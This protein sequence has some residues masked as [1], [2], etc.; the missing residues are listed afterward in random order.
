MSRLAAVEA[1][2]AALP[3]RAAWILFVALGLTAAA[4]VSLVDPRTRES[5]LAMDA[6][7]DRLLPAHDPARQLLDRVEAQFGKDETLLV[8]LSSEG[9]FRTETLKRVDAMTRRLA[10]LEGVDRVLSLTTGT[11]VR[12]VDGDVQIGPLIE[13]IPEDA[14]GLAALRQRVEDDPLVGRNLVSRDGRVTALLVYFLPMSNRQYRDMGLDAAIEKVAY[15]E[16]GDGEVWVTGGP[17][18]RSVTADILLRETLGLSLGILGALGLVLLLAYRTARGVLVPLATIAVAVLWTMGVVAWVG[19]PL[20]AVT[21]LVPPLLT[22][23]GLSYAVHVLTAYYEALRDPGEGE[24]HAA[25]VGRALTEVALPVV[26][27]GVTTAAGLASLMLSPLAAVRDFG[28]YSV[29]GVLLMLIASLTFTPA[30]LAVMGRPRRVPAEEGGVFERFIDRVAHFDLRHRTTVF[31]VC[32]GFFAVSMFGSAALR[33][34]TRQVDKFQP[35]APVRTDF[36]NVNRAFD[37]ANPLYVVLSSEAPDAF[38]EP[39]NLAELVSLQ[40][41]L[42]D[43]PEIGAATSV[44]DFLAM[45]HQ[46]FQGGD[47]AERRVPDSRRLV[48]QLLFFGAGEELDRYVDADYQMISIHLRANVLDSA[49][50]A[51]LA[52]RIRERLAE[53]PGHIEGHVTGT[54]VVLT[55]ALDS[56][57]RSQLWSLGAAFLI[58][59]AILVSMFLDLRVGFLALIPNALPV[60]AYFGAL[61]FFGVRLDP[62]T[63]LVAPMVLGIA[64]DDT[65]HY[66]ASFIKETRRTADEARATHLALR[67]VG[68]PV[69]I[70]TIALCTAFLWLTTSE[71]Q[72]NVELG[73]FAAFALALAWA[74]DFFLTPALCTQLRIATLWDVLS[75]DLGRAPHK[76]IALFDGLTASQARVVAVLAEFVEAKRGEHLFWRGERGD[77]VYVVVT[78]ELRAKLRFESGSRELTRMGRG[79]TVGEVGLLH[80]ARSADVEVMADAKLIRLTEAALAGLTRTSPRIA[81][82]LYRNLSSAAAARLEEHSAGLA[83][84]HGARA[85]EASRKAAAAG[86]ELADAFFAGASDEARAHL[87]RES[88]GAADD[89]E[90]GV[91]LRAAGLDEDAIAATLLVPLAEVAWADDHL[92]PKERAAVLSALSDLGIDAASPAL[93]VLT[94]WLDQRPDRAL[95]D[96]WQQTI[97]ATTAALSVEGRLGLKRTVLGRAHAL[98]SAAGGFLGLASV[99]SHEEEVL[100]RLEK[101]FAVGV[102]DGSDGRSD[103]SAGSPSLPFT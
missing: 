23:I 53:L 72:T 101:A 9:V 76:E 10:A 56:V 86:R 46:G 3:R 16:R 36:E 81:A 83:A 78:G 29:L 30:V 18:I 11:T 38:K 20:N 92:D 4:A 68:R 13:K 91:R 32:A 41:W 67:A 8:A 40:Q 94:R 77:A 97:S 27:T 26:L 79:A 65:I 66:F 12:S 24:A 50:T 44:A 82:V 25:L 89:V 80:M 47:I 64:V 96:A 93:H 52:D 6:S 49:D 85:T 98:A 70:T 88:M 73:I 17:H 37:G 34:G 35:D 54:A 45:L 62:G 102:A 95:L 69:T 14:A 28:I 33:V 75:L 99:S 1:V 63:S 15:V 61:G 103:N 39:A 48:S 90:I 22:A 100:S 58:I 51:V 5:R 87:T 74:T 59:Y 7:A 21:A 19:E 71:L 84:D 57:V 43:Q 2:F 31:A 60:A 55:S 42:L